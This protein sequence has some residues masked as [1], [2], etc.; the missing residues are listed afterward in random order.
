M[1]KH[2]LVVVTSP[3][4][5]RE[6]EYNQWY[7]EQHLPDVL[8]VPGFTAAQRFKLLSH[9]PG[10]LPGDYLAIYEFEPMAPIDDPRAVFAALAQATASGQMPIS[11]AM[12]LARTT[13]S[14]FAPI[15]GRQEKA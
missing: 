13:A 9:S 12:D 5:G 11:P 4:P 3:M 7:D 1:D 15:T 2:I 14:V 8:R 6:D 10:S